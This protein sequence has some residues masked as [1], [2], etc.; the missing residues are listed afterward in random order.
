MKP[1]TFFIVGHGYLLTA[2]FASSQ[3]HQAADFVGALIFF[4]LTFISILANAKR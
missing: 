1:D 3:A 4:G 2:Q